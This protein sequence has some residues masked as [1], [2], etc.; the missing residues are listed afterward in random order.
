M[1]GV[2]DKLTDKG[3]GFIRVEGEEKGIF[4]HASGLAEG[5]EFNDLQEG[6][7]V[8]FEL[9]ET[10]RG[11]NAVNVSKVEADAEAQADAE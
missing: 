1:Q 4:F 8:S 10:D 9:T 11:K 2:I 5:V 7:T 6:D 3:F